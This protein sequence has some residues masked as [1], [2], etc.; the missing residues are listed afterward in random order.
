MMLAVLAAASLYAVAFYLFYSRLSRAKGF[1]SV[2]FRVLKISRLLKRFDNLEEK[3][4]EV[5]KEA[6]TFLKEKKGEFFGVFFLSPFV[7]FAWLGEIWLLAY[8]LGVNL[9]F[10][11]VVLVQFFLGLATLAPVSG[12]LGFLEAGSA[13]A[14]VLLGFQGAGGL[15]FSILQRIKDLILTAIGLLSFLYFGIKR[16]ISF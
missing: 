11:E 1:F 15:S 4:L 5:E 7:Y 8:F 10:F 3:I 12:G 9:D 16:G 6:S 2:L 14:F 13:A